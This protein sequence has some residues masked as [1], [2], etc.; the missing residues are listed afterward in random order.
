MLLEREKGTYFWKAYTSEL[1]N[2]DLKSMFEAYS[3]ALT[4]NIMQLDEVREKMG[5]PPLGFNYI[6]LGLDTVLID[7]DKNIVYTPNTNMVQNFKETQKTA[8]PDIEGEGSHIS[9]E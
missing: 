4:G 6:K 8:E 9:E 5:L 3:I 1:E 7:P 2:G